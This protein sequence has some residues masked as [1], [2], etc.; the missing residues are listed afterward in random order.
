MRVRDERLYGCLYY[1]NISVIGG[2]GQ[3][4]I[5]IDCY[6]FMLSFMGAVCLTHHS[7]YASLYTLVFQPS[8]IESGEGLRANNSRWIQ[9][10]RVEYM[11]TRHTKNNF[12][13]SINGEQSS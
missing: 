11:L 4:H 2:T 3:F 8:R 6:E 10:H 13:L 7:N 12:E 5:R 9:L 1:I